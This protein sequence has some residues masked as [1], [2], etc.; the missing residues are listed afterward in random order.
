MTTADEPKAGALLLLAAMVATLGI[1]T[2]EALYPGYS[3][4]GNAISDLGGILGTGEVHQPSAI[5]FD[6]SMAIT[7]LLILGATAFLYRGGFDRAT[8]VLL[9]ANGLGLFLVGVFPEPTGAPH[10]VAALIT[11]LG[12]GGAAVASSRA[13]EGPFR[14]VAGILGIVA[15]VFLGLFF[16]AG[17]V[18]G[19]G[20]GGTERWIAYPVLVWTAGFGGLLMGGAAPP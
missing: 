14:Y 6:V 1:L 8:A 2:A 9:G 4:H 3:V 12:G 7:G 5:I 10:L 13:S 16:T 11:F 20:L 18:A 17:S 19:L 15:L